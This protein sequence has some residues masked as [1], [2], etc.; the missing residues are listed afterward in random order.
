MRPNYPNARPS[1]V[2]H[3]LAEDAGTLCLLIREG[4]KSVP[5]SFELVRI[6]GDLSS[7]R[8]CTYEW[9]AVRPPW[10]LPA[11][12]PR[13]PLASPRLPRII[14]TSSDLGCPTRPLAVSGGL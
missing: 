6:F 3:R 5:G 13:S 8:S 7:Y 2:G 11:W 12:L 10:W 4:P 1:C 9:T 14:S